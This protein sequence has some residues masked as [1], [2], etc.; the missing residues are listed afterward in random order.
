MHLSISNSPRSNLRYEK[1]MILATNIVYIL[2]FVLYLNP[3]LL[4]TAT[5]FLYLYSTLLRLKQ[6]ISTLNILHSAKITA[7]GS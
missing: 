4:C 1:L 7:C 5:V 6:N 2:D 3:F